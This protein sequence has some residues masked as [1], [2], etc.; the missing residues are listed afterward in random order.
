MLRHMWL[1]REWACPGADPVILALRKPWAPAQTQWC[2]Q[3][4]LPCVT[5]QGQ[6]LS[7][8]LATRELRQQC[9]EQVPARGKVGVLSLLGDS[10]VL[11]SR[12]LAQSRTPKNY[13]WS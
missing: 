2:L 8:K 10:A 6:K 5:L 1:W 3:K 4:S 11:H 13:L 7:S 9:A 12:G